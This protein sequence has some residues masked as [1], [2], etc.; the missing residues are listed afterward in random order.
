MRILA[1]TVKR[2]KIKAQTMKNRMMTT[3]NRTSTMAFM[4][5]TLG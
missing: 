4:L 5:M 2:K 1:F 3:M